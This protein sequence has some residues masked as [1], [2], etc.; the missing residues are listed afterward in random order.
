MRVPPYRPEQTSRSTLPNSPLQQMVELYISDNALTNH[1][2][3]LSTPEQLAEVSPSPT[4]PGPTR[5]PKPTSHA[6]EGII[7]WPTVSS[8]VF[9]F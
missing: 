3:K 9:R 1:S 2:P 7:S 5:P 8:L 4:I 6:I